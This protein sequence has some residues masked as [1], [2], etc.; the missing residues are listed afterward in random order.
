MGAG[1]KTGGALVR[2]LALVEYFLAV[3]H[4]FTR[5]RPQPNRV[6]GRFR[7]ATFL[8]PPFKLQDMGILKKTNL[9]DLPKAFCQKNPIFQPCFKASAQTRK[10][11]SRTR[12]VFSKA[13]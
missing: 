2:G 4:E 8:F 3:I 10:A 9:I 13:S 12:K 7:T 6:E 5:V 1:I 11:L